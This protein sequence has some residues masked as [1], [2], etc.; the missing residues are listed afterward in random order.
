MAIN[1]GLWTLPAT[2]PV[3]ANRSCCGDGESN[4]H[5]P[6]LSS[7][8]KKISLWL[9][10]LHLQMGILFS[11]LV[12]FLYRVIK[13]SARPWQCKLFSSHVHLISS[14]FP[15]HET[16]CCK[17]GSSVRQSITLWRR[18]SSPAVFKLCMSFS[19][20]LMFNLCFDYE[21]FAID[22]VGPVL[23]AFSWSSLKYTSGLSSPSNN[24]ESPKICPKHC[25]SS[26]SMFKASEHYLSFL[27]GIH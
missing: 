27:V 15:F 17:W 3:G 24:S 1:K 19:L 16:V 20:F 11:Y 4:E 26:T 5:M 21:H 8:K 6:C 25:S 18:S 10:P 13:V 23:M 14:F 2:D 22:V 12:T 7:F 9:V